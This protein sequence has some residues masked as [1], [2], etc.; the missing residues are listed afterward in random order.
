MTSLIFGALLTFSSSVLISE[1][2]RDK[3]SFP[4]SDEAKFLAVSLPPPSFPKFLGRRLF[5]SILLFWKLS[6]RLSSIFFETNLIYYFLGFIL[7]PIVSYSMSIF[8]VSNFDRWTCAIP[9]VWTLSKLALIDFKDLWV[10]LDEA[11]IQLLAI[12]E[13]MIERKLD[14]ACEPDS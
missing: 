10:F 11:E 14:E 7:C 3:K 8:S 13:E 9:K 5:R 1:E 2:A 4:S 6:E 12:Y